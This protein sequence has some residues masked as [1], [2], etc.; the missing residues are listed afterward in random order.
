LKRNSIAAF[1]LH[2]ATEHAYAALL[3][4][5]TG[6]KPKLHDIEKLGDQVAQCDLHFL[7]VFPRQTPEQKKRFEL[8]KSAYV[9][10]RYKKC[11]KI[12]LEELEYLGEC[13]K[14]LHSL[15]QE[16]CNRKIEELSKN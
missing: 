9:D 15:V 2:Q 12:T 7:A 13:V 10:A 6:Y 8:L 3:L 11:Y 4:V 16:S 1:Y 5:Y 14:N